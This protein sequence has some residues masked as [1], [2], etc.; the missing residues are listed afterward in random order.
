MLEK[1][2]HL[3]SCKMFDYYESIVHEWFLYIHVREF[4]DY[5]ILSQISCYP[6]KDTP[7]LMYSTL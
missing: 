5:V 7:D 2:P 3:K 6:I 4:N 1:I